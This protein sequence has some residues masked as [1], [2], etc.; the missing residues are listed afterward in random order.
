MMDTTWAIMRDYITSV[1]GVILQIAAVPFSAAFGLSESVR[2][3]RI[4][5]FVFF[6]TKKLVFDLLV[7]AKGFGSVYVGNVVQEIG[8]FQ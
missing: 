5:F 7:D 3:L 4:L 2:S 6:M 8:E 1:L